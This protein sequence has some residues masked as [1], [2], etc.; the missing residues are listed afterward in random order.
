M[1]DKDKKGAILI[2]AVVSVVVALMGV[3]FSLSQNDK[4][5]ARNCVGKPTRST[6][7][8]I[9]KTDAIASQTQSEIESRIMA[10]VNERVETNELV[11]VFTVSQLSKNNLTPALTLCRPQDKGNVTH[12]DVRGIQVRYQK[13]FIE[14][15]KKVVSTQAESSPQSPIAQAITDLTLS[16]YLRSET[17]T[18]MIFSDMIE[19]VPG[20]YSMFSCS[21][22]NEAIQ[23]YKQSASGAERRPD[24]KNVKIHLNIIPR[25]DLKRSAVECRD[26]FWSWFFTSH[27]DTAAPRHSG[28]VLDYLPGGILKK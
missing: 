12:E 10:H 4:A 24:F 18:L 5:D 22:P 23:V 14:P 19:H 28:V 3:R 27:S 13:N 7:I 15:L 25:D 20:R 2:V 8:L 11:S 21:N 9:D 6:V 1:N 16:G 26:K 17:N